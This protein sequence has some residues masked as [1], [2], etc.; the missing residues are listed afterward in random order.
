MLLE[1]GDC[2]PKLLNDLEY[3]KK[4]MISAAEAIG[5]TIVGQSFHKFSPQG[6]TG[7]LA[8][9][10]S[11]L[12]IHTWPEYSYA[13]ADLFTCGNDIDPKIAANILIEK[14]DSKKPEQ[15]IIRR[16]I[17]SLPLIHRV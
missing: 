12:S 15:R 1:L 8:I 7:V 11:H 17:K 3:V 5:A 14:L 9:A 13:A 2:N 10:E 4:T 16:G 6:V